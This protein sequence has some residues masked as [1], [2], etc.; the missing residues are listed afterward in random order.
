MY[1]YQNVTDIRGNG[2]IGMIGL[3]ETMSYVVDTYTGAC[4]LQIIYD[5]FNVRLTSFFYGIETKSF[6]ASDNCICILYMI[7]HNIL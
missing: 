4:F 2:G 7:S 3:L 1:R 6:Y 5:S